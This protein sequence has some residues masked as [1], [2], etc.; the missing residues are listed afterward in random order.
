MVAPDRPARARRADRVR[1]LRP[2]AARRRHAR[3]RRVVGRRPDRGRGNGR[4]RRDRP[5]HRRPRARRSCRRRASLRRAPAVTWTVNGRELTLTPGDRRPPRRSS[6]G[7]I[8]ARPRRARRAH[9]DRAARRLGHGRGRDAAR[10]D[11]SAVGRTRGVALRV[12]SGDVGERVIWRSPDRRLLDAAP[13]RGRG[14]D[15]RRCSCRR[16]ARARPVAAAPAPGS[17]ARSRGARRR[18]RRRADAQPA[19]L[20]LGLRRA[21]GRPA[22]PAR[23]TRLSAVGRP[24]RP[25]AV[26]RRQGGP[27][28]A[29]LRARDRSHAHRGCGER[30]A[31]PGSRARARPRGCATGSPSSASPRRRAVRPTTPAGSGCIR[32]RRS[33]AA[34]AG[35]SRS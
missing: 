4:D 5:G 1:P 12:A 23:R 18:D 11:L 30:R 20:G 3:A 9:R 25:D 29:L 15:G 10:T 22:R 28:R 16:R 27:V 6:T 13:A 31:H 24:V 33:C 32:S 2:A 8:A 7:S 14:R 35:R 34:V 26:H 21:R 17:P 19:L